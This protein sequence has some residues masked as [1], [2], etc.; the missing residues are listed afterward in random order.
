MRQGRLGVS[1]SRRARHGIFDGEPPRAA[2]LRP[3]VVVVTL[4][5]AES[6]PSGAGVTRTSLSCAVSGH[7]TVPRRSP[8]S[9]PV[10]A[11]AGRSG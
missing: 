10:G 3:A 5:A 2:G 9:A 1:V 6:H 7:R 8:L 11:A 4:S